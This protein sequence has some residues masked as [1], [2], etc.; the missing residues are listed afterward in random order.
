MSSSYSHSEAG[1]CEEQWEVLEQEHAQSLKEKLVSTKHQHHSVCF[2]FEVWLLDVQW[3]S[4]QN[5]LCDCSSQGSCGW[6]SVYQLWVL[7]K[8]GCV[9]QR[10]LVTAWKQGR[11]IISAE[12][13]LS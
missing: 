11:E 13:L 7:E 10:V 1:Q 4:P 9:S 6:G 5:E 12:W 3:L 2:C 8:A